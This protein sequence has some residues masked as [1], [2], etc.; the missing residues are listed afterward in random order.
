MKTFQ[1]GSWK[2]YSLL[3]CSPH[4]TLH[5]LN[6]QTLAHLLVGTQNYHGNLVS[7]NLLAKP[8]KSG[9]IHSYAHQHDPS[10]FLGLQ[11]LYSVVFSYNRCQTTCLFDINLLC[12]KA[13]GRH[14]PCHKIQY[15][16]GNLLDLG[17]F[18]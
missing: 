11:P 3:H 16:L 17:S 18:C 8:S 10:R 6:L 13:L 15:K 7:L 14:C 2:T 5:I 1:E 9:L 4:S 12:L